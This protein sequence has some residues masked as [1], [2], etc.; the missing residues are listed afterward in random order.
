MIIFFILWFSSNQMDHTPQLM[1]EHRPESMRAD[2]FI[3]ISNMSLGD[4]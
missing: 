1:S 3:H 2:G 4:N